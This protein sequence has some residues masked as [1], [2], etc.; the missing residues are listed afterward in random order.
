LRI[1]GARRRNQFVASTFS[2][3]G[4]DSFPLQSQALEPGKR[5]ITRLLDIFCIHI[6]CSSCLPQFCYSSV[7]CH[8][9]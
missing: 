9:P 7:F 6:F 3:V 4:T 5:V 2:V 8:L 1:A